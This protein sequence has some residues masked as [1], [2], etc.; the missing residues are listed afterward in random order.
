MMILAV[1][2]FAC[3]F[4]WGITHFC[5]VWLPNWQRRRYGLF[6][7][8]RDGNGMCAIQRNY[9]FPLGWLTETGFLSDESVDREL[10]RLMKKH[11]QKII[12]VVK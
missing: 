6:R 1:L 12:R 5:L 4:G 2:C 7:V 3:L 11:Q 8:I 10:D 9:G